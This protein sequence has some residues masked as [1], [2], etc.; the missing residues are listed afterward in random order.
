VRE[1]SLG[2]VFVTKSWLSGFCKPITNKL[3]TSNYL[4]NACANLIAPGGHFLSQPYFNQKR[5]KRIIISLLAIT[6]SLSFGCKDNETKTKEN[7]VLTRKTAVYD[8]TLAQDWAKMA[9]QMVRENNLS[10]P[11]EARVY[12]YVGLTIWESVCNGIPKANTLAG[13]INAYNYA[14]A[15]DVTKEYDW[16]IVLCTAMSVVLPQLIEGVTAAQRSQIDVLAITQEAEMLADG[17]SSEVR[18]DSKA[19]GMEISAKILQRMHNDGFEVARNLTPVVPVRDADHRWYWSPA[20]PNQQPVEPLWSTLRTFVLDN[21]QHCEADA[22]YPYSEQPGSAFYADAQEV[23][24][25]PRIN[26]NRSIAYHWEDGSSRTGGPASH[27]MSIT[28]QM[29]QNGEKNLAECARAYCLVGCTLADAFSVC[30]YLKYKYNQLL[31]VTYIREQIN[32]NWKPWVYNPP[33]PEYTSAAATVGGA[34]PIVLASVLGDIAFVDRTQLGSAL[35][36]PDG[37][38]F[39]LPERAFTSLT[40]A[41]EEQAISGLYG[42]IHFRRACELGLQSGRCVGHTLLSRLHFGF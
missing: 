4:L 24:E 16:G 20:T 39:V 25:S 23:Y 5:M 6:L 31:P 2:Y 30:W 10:C 33:F 35:Y 12:G 11:Q 18:F 26:T 3:I 15:V 19:L 28:T 36:T 32:P 17:P 42:G 13:Q 1:I 14:A 7:K 22:T 38:P 37:G 8:G 9:G 27:W 41:G 40:K 34:V 29:L 21:A